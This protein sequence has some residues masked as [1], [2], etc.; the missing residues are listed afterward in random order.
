MVQIG[1]I[2]YFQKSTP[3]TRGAFKY[4]E[5][6]SPNDF[7]PLIRG[8]EPFCRPFPHRKM[9]KIKFDFLSTDPCFEYSTYTSFGTIQNIKFKFLRFSVGLSKHDLPNYPG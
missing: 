3:R 1:T 5:P 2:F 7:F 8:S 9:A 6:Y 4:H